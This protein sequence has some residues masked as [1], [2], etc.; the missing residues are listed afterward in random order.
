ME[1]M[2]FADINSDAVITELTIKLENLIE[3]LSVKHKP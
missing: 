2:T 1:Q 3:T